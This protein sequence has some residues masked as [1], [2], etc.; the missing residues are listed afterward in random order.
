M[1]KVKKAY[2][3]EIDIL[4]GFATILVVLGHILQYSMMQNEAFYNDFLFKVIYSFHMPLFM[5]IS[6]FLF[7][8]SYDKYGKKTYIYRQLLSLGKV[9]LIW[10]AI[11]WILNCLLGVYSFDCIVDV[12]K[13][14]YTAFSG[15]WYIYIYYKEY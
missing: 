14:A 6:G 13:S 10:N 9:I 12:M 15:L 5:C 3:C 1:E 4:R 7:K 8:H 11:Q 2:S